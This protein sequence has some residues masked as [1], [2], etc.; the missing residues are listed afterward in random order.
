M[1]QRRMEMRNPVGTVSSLTS[2]GSAVFPGQRYNSYRLI[3][4]FKEYK[5]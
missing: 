1:D 2:T 4:I 5:W 3:C